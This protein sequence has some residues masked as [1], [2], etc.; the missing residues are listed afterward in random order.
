MDEFTSQL[1]IELSPIEV[2]YPVYLF[3]YVSAGGN[4][5]QK[6]TIQL[7]TPAIDSLVENLSQKIRWRKSAAG[8][9]ALMTTR[10]RNFIKER[11]GHAC[12]TCFASVAVEPNLLLEIDHIVPVSRGRLSTPENLQTLCWRCNRTKSNKIMPEAL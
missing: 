10:L 7:N 9:R 4:S 8:Q 11:D 12:K 6:A 2:P 5:G 3:E 1:G